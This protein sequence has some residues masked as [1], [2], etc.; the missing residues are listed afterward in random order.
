M[1]CSAVF[2]FVMCGRVGFCLRKQ[3]L[4]FLATVMMPHFLVK[5]Q[6]PCSII[7]LLL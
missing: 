5:L 1:L 3:L 6:L 4:L 7:I 2:S